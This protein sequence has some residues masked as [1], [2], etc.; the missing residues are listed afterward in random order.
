MV[1]ENPKCVDGL[2]LE[3]PAFKLH[4]ATAAWY[5]VL[6]A[7]LLSAIAPK[8]KVGKVEFPFISR[9]IDVNKEKERLSPE[10]GDCGGMMASVAAHMMRVQDKLMPELSQIQVPTLICSGTDDKLTAVSGS[11]Y[12]H[13]QIQNSKLKLYQGAYH[14]LHDELPETT[15][16]FMK[17]VQEFISALL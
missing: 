6:G 5:I 12:A 7:K 4:E 1:K 9:N 15:E 2:I 16:E 13:S 10:Y 14:A 11:E 17:D 8:T 3:A